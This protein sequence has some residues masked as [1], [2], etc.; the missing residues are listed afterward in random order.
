MNVKNRSCIRRL[1]RKSM[2]ASKTRN[3][4]AATAIA[5]TTV[6]FTA[7]FTIAMSINESFQDANFRQVGGFA[8]GGF[9]YLT[10]EQYETLKDDKDIKEYGTRRVIGFG[11]G[12]VFAKKHVEI[13]WCDPNEAE[14]MY[15][16]PIEGRLP[17][18]GTNETAT[19]LEILKL[20]GVEPKIGT[21]FTVPVMVDDR[22]ETTLTLT[23]CGWWEKDPIVMANHI[24]I[25]ESLVDQILEENEVTPPGANG[26]TG[27]WN[28]DVMLKNSLHIEKDLQTIL[29]RPGYQSTS[30]SED[31][32]IRIGV[33]WGYTGAQMSRNFDP[34]TVAVV[35][36]LLLLIVF[37]GYLIIY[38]VFQISVANDIRFYGLLKTIGTTGKQ[39]KRLIRI[40]ALLLSSVGIPVG[41][42]AG[43]LL[44][45]R[46]TPVILS[47]LEGV[48]NVVSIQPLIFVASAVFALVTVLLSCRKPGKMAAKVSPI[49]AVRYT[50]NVQMKKKT[51]KSGKKFSLFLM[52]KANLG[53][54][55]GKTCVTV[56]S[57]S[58]ALVILNLTVT[59][60]NGF[61]MEKYLSARVVTDGI[62]S[63]AEYFQ[64]TRGWGGSGLTEDVITDIEAQ[65]GVA[66][67]GRIY[68]DTT[69]NLEYISEDY[70]RGKNERY[71]SAEELEQLA[72]SW[73]RN[74]KGEMEDHVQLYG[75]EA[76]ALDKLNVVEGDISGLYEPGSHCIAAVVTDDD[77]G[78]VI[79]D[80]N[81]AKVGDKI[82]LR[83]V[84]E[85]EN[86]NTD[87][88]EILDMPEEEIPEA[89]NYECRAVKYRDV[90]YEVTAL[91]T[92]PSSLSYRY[93]GRDEF[94]LN[95][96]TFMEDTRSNQVMLYTFDTKDQASSEAMEEFLKNYTETVHSEC[97]F[98]S[99]QSYAR[100]FE[101]FRS[102]FLLLGGTLSFIVGIVGILNFFNAILTG[103][104]TRKR[105]F[106]ML[107]SI[108]MTGK[109]L[110][111][112]LIWEGLFYALSAAGASLVLNLILCPLA[113]KVLAGMFWFF[114]Y[115]FTIWPVVAA[116]PVFALMGILIPLGLYRRAVKKSI[117]E[118]LRESE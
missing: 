79:P 40:Q 47:R 59:F 44:G 30:A 109:Q 65:P 111:I 6:L 34:M 96:Q 12:D 24:L 42:L 28:M 84:D 118:R 63:R 7:L 72:K 1:S 83:H 14:W 9:K 36:I 70:W 37:T 20:L 61:D 66:D 76:F 31:N 10:E 62:V 58:L 43:W 73:D 53:R 13:S 26:S 82:T 102:M 75:M 3:I 50:E 91:V 86:Y 98:E 85:F 110:K 46:L 4:I 94:V 60:T 80:S 17:K 107:Q 8:H 116:I 18:E 88:G 97:D 101:R 16:E 11:T 99:R 100:E 38:N 92:V 52:A 45:A 33:N 64:V 106:A 22:I 95:A 93:Y 87:T 41:L 105:E 68:G 114:T 48:G 81:W 25:P 117:V 5:L 90:E 51:R 54:N 55:R 21:E 39:I 19:D 71:Y 35:I 69:W 15:C 56:I 57:L 78:K 49:E 77:Y 74:E 115:R 2:W 89:I 23:L 112:M 113:A 104:I 108:G 103:L 29:E 27:C 67:G 32:Y